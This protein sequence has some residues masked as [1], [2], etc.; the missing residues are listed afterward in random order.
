MVKKYDGEF[1]QIHFK[2]ILDYLDLEEEKFFEIIDK[3]RPQHLWE[4]KS[5]EWELLQAVWKN[6]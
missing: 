5:G 6:K 3:F 4:K 1:P 2:E